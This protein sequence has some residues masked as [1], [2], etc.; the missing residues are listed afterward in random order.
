M[1]YEQKNGHLE[2]DG[3]NHVLLE[4]SD[5]LFN[6]EITI[7]FWAKGTGNTGT[8][9]SLLEGFDTLNNRII[10]LPSSQSLILK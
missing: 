9:T 8:N 5:T 2:F 3:N 1:C 10:N 4:F 6:D 7:E